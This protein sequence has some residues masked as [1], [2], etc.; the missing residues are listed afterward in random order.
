MG[1]PVVY[2]NENLLYVDHSPDCPFDALFIE[3]LLHCPVY[4]RV[5]LLPALIV[6]TYVGRNLA[7]HG[8]II[9]FGYVNW[10]PRWFLDNER[11]QF[12]FVWVLPFLGFQA[13]L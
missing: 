8:A 7:F 1:Y 5:K 12:A 10:V 6:A 4:Y 9:S 2:P 13:Q 3:P 11:R